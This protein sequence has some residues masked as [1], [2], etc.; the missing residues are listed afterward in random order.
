MAAQALPWLVV[1]C[2]FVLCRWAYYR[3][4][5]RFNSDPVYYFAQLLDPYL[6]S[7]RLL[8]SILYL[9]AQPPLFNLLTGL[10]LKLGGEHV[11]VLLW[12]FYLGVALAILILF[13]RT[14]TRLAVP[15]WLALAVSVAFCCA[16][17][18]RAV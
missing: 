1:V 4:G 16:P 14:L 7:H 9:H 3:A 15:T 5:V 8:E 17:P 10:A 18:P 6:L 13:F 2:A 11:D 12:A